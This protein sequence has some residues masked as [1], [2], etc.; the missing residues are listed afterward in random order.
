MPPGIALADFY[1]ILPELVLTG[2]S[3][4]VLIADVRCRAEGGWLAWITHIGATLASL[5]PLR[6]EVAHG[7]I[8][9]SS[10]WLKVASAPPP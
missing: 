3:L 10:R 5:I 4:L 6:N 8:A 9:I 2:G 1:Y 7:L